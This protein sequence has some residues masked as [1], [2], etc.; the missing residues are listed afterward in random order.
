MLTAGYAIIKTVSA[1]WRMSKAGLFL[2]SGF[3]KLSLT[4]LYYE[5]INQLST[6]A[7]N[8]LVFLKILSRQIFHLPVCS[9][10]KN[11]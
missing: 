4:E 8:L 7:K 11:P 10:L 1:G 2:H 6:R 3:D 9:A 5:F